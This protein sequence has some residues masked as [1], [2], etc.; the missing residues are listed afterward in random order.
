MPKPQTSVFSVKITHEKSRVGSEKLELAPRSLKVSQRLG[1]LVRRRRTNFAF[2]RAI[3][4][5][6]GHRLQYGFFQFECLSVCLSVCLGEEKCNDKFF[7]QQLKKRLKE[8]EF[9]LGKNGNYKI[10]PRFWPHTHNFEVLFLKIRTC[11][12]TRNLNKQLL[13]GFKF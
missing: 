3:D 2:Q 13:M 11:L 6:A 10:T 8:I 7:V 4:E 9:D 12:Q 1:F 5:N